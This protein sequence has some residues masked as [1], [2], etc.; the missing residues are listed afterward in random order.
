[1][2][3][4]IVDRQYS[5]CRELLAL[6]KAFSEFFMI[7]V[8]G[9]HLTPEKENQFLQLKSRIAELHDS[10]LDALS[11]DQNVGQAML[12][13]VSRSITLKHLNRLSTADVKKMEIEWHESYLLL[14]DT[15]GQLEDK[16]N[17]LAQINETQY[18]SKKAVGA[19]TQQITNF[20]TSAGFKLTLILSAVLFATI[21]VQAFD[22]FDWDTF[23]HQKWATVPYR[24]GKKAVR[25]VYNPDS[26]WVAIDNAPR[27]P[28][29]SW[30]GGL[31]EPKV[32]STN[33]KDLME[34][35]PPEMPAE[36]KDIFSKAKEYR[37][38]MTEK[39]FRG[40]LYI[41]SILLP[42]TGQAKR[43]VDWFDQYADTK[44]GKDLV[45]NWR[46]LRD[47]NVVTIITS[48]DT[49]MLHGSWLDIFKQPNKF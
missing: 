27:E 16:R 5:D 8:K 29:I 7:G 44:P 39:D 6:W 3:D 20:F 26:E 38:E 45:K 13:V 46:M 21:G 32:E 12:D 42:E 30:P 25:K 48:T 40:K 47:T 17:E 18:R 1:M 35:L 10:F 43:A 22:V 41:H 4:P 9:E 37:R 36:I 14:N 11:H 33:V 49:E 31:K 23:G 28:Y 2:I 15:I 24:W 34:T 19:I